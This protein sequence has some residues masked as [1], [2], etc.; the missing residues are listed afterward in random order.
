MKR[1][2]FEL[3]RGLRQ[4]RNLRHS[5]LGVGIVATVAVIFAACTPPHHPPVGTTTTTSTTTSTTTTS[6][7]TTT[8]TT[9]TPPPTGFTTEALSQS[10]DGTL[11]NG[12]SQNQ[13]MS[14]DGR[15][16]VFESDADNLVEDDTN[17]V[18]DI[19]LHDRETGEI[20]RITVNEQGEQANGPSW[21]TAISHDGMRIAFES[22]ATNLVDIDT[23]GVTQV[24]V[25]ATW[26][27]SVELLSVNNA[28]EA[29]NGP[30]ANPS[31]GRV[32]VHAYFDSAATN[33]VNNDINGHRDVF[34]RD[35]FTRRTT[36]VSV[37]SSG[38]QGNGDSTNPY[39]GEH[40]AAMTFISEASNLVPGDTN[41]V[42]DIFFRSSI[43]QIE[44]ISISSTGEQAN[45]AST[46]HA[47]LSEDLRYVVFASQAMNLTNDTTNGR[48]NIYLRD[49]VAGATSL[50]SRGVNGEPAN[51]DSLQPEMGLDG[52]FIV[53][54]S[55]ADNIVAGDTNG[56]RDVFLYDTMTNSM[57]LVSLHTWG[58]QGNGDS[59]NP[60][61]TTDGGFV[62]YDSVASN[63]IGDDSN[64]SADVFQSG[65]LNV[66]IPSPQPSQ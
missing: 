21:N 39:V 60:M 27:N 48:W 57:D 20:R 43:R 30:S 61:V 49:R 4:Q 36:L 46:G 5:I 37:T 29:G 13:S 51:G 52:R 24:Y 11:G 53:F 62:A 47:V 65:D 28:G 14:L 45:A 3:L 25:I 18:S 54:S 26:F 44:R 1:V 10:V 64:N 8:T 42:T 23:N 40:H 7:S 33:L 35:L 63:L 6:T 15:Y 12:R 38:V 50:I 16:V 9:T 17:G 2:G 41:G 55:N 66:F 31:L 56:R 59:L 22:S 32:G 34:M 58:Q 19:F